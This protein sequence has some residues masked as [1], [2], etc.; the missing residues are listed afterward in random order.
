VALL[1]R[2]RISE[3]LG[4]GGMGVVY[5]ALDEV[6]GRRVAI[7]RL[8][9]AVDAESAER[10][11]R[12]ARVA[13]AVLHPHVCQ[14]FDM[15]E[16]EEGPYLVMELLQGEPLSRRLER[17]PMALGE[18]GALAVA[19]LS[20]LGALHER[21]VVHRDLKPSNMFLTP[22]GLKLLD[23]GLARPF[24]LAATSDLAVSLPDLTATGL[25]AGTPR[26]MSPEQ[27]RGE[28]LDARSDLFSLGAVLYE[29][30]AGEPAFRGATAA[31]LVHA[32]LA[33]QPP[34]LTGSPG[35]AAVNRVLLE[36]LAKRRDDRP[37]DAPTMARA[38]ERALALAGAEA[39]VE[40]R[41]LRR[42]IVL[43]FRLVRP[44][45][46][47]DF[48]GGAL[49]EAVTGALASL[50]SL[51]VRSSLFA[52]RFTDPQPDLHALAAEADVDMALVGTLLRS[53]D[54][55]RLA[56]QLVEVPSG[57]LLGAC[58]AE[59]SLGD[60]FAL[61]DALTQRLVAALELPLSERERRA[62]RGE[63][64]RSPVAHEFFLR[65]EQQGPGARAWSVARDFYQRALDAD[66]RYAPAWVGLARVEWL[67]GKYGDD[68]AGR[69]RAAAAMRRALALAPDLPAA[70]V[71]AAR[72]DEGRGRPLDA[73]RC[74]LALAAKTP[75]DARPFAGLV[76]TCRIAG[77]AE[78][79]LAAHREARRLDRKVETSVNQTHH[80]L[81]DFEH[82]LA[83]SEAD[84]GYAPAYCLARLGRQGEAL[85]LVRQRE[86]E[87]P[88]GLQRQWL[89]SLR[90]LLGEERAPALAALESLLQ[91]F[92]DP[93]G[94]A[95]VGLSFCRLG[96]PARALAALER[97]AELGF[98]LVE[99]LERDP[100]LDPLR[101]E[102]AFVEI[103]GGARQRAAEAA[104]IF[105]AAGGERLL[106][107]QP[108]VPPDPPTT[109]AGRF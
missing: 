28:P 89:A 103:V 41:T 51:A 31:D 14:L 42:L 90:G 75:A 16:D 37:P 99:P 13:A 32:V 83:E 24:P 93:D 20:A 106:G 97:A 23:F 57:T 27:L 69:E 2:Y 104:A 48:L 22:H 81:G 38:L 102:P 33:E 35:V 63:A 96:E 85:A 65:A 59:G 66:S 39:K 105:S 10:L 108:A 84:F 100:W 60:L 40:A 43:P 61:Q 34:A 71:L 47:I 67:I 36:A 4:A 98:S 77:L 82:A 3:Q 87:V 91:E 45:P 46:E 56:C 88:A 74:L 95:L 30:L 92:P 21:G 17:G 5:A 76:R 58:T 25:I 9:G 54:A 52:A 55:L 18:A 107:L 78:A 26:Y 44:D 7:K 29:M 73:M 12:E 1:G 72:M 94:L 101:D 50:S 70:Q 109:L 79:S 80:F 11:R 68:P 53:G 62:L 15:G 86:A 49:A 6:L 8:T 64:P 19:A